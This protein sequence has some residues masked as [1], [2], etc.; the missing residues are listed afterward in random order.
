M[1]YLSAGHNHKPVKPDP[2]AVGN[3]YKESDLTIELRDLIAKE[4]TAKGY[5]FIIDKDAETLAEYVA[6]IKPGSGSVVCEIHFNAGPVSA[7]GVE[8]LYRATDKDSKA[9]ADEM[10]F[11]LSHIMN[12]ANRGGKDESMSHRGRL[13]ILHTAAGTAVL[14]EICFIS[15]KTDMEKYQKNKN[16]IAASIATLLIKYENMFS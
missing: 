2:G 1:I 12:M 7:T 10:A 6:R 13:A 5:P 4:I 15:N 14:P 8:V 11:S 3:G 16:A 9:L